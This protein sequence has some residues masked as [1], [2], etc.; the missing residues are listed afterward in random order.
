MNLYKEFKNILLNN[1]IRWILFIC[2]LILN[3]IAFIQ[4][5]IRLSSGKC[6]G[7]L[8]CKWFGYLAGMGTFTMDCLT[9]IGLWLTIPFT[10]G[11]SD[12]WFIPFILIGYAIITEITLNSNIYKKD[13]YDGEDNLDPPP[14]YLLSIN[15]RKIIYGLILIIDIIIFFQFY[16]ASGLKKLSGNVKMIDILFL[17]R[18]GGYNGNEIS[19]IMAWVGSLGIVMDIIA[20]NMCSNY[21]P[22]KYNQPISWKN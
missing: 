16:L 9:F 3:F 8:P 4:D 1:S 20:Y 13:E 7:G 15:K 11:L 22:C 17:N 14:N 2:V 19:F 12:Y 10:S 21:I 5:P 6:I 18:F